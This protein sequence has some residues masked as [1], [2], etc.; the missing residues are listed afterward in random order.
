MY[1]PTVLHFYSP[2]NLLTVTLHRGVYVAVFGAMSGDILAQLLSLL[3][4]VN[5]LLP[6]TYDPYWNVFIQVGKKI[7]V[8][9]SRSVNM[10]YSYT[11]CM[12]LL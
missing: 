4:H 1:L 3:L 7:M 6:L 2:I 9:R 11:C 8:T 5:P 12:C 10:Q